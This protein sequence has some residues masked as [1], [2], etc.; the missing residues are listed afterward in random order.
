MNKPLCHVSTRDI[1]SKHRVERDTENELS[2]SLSTKH[3][4]FP[5]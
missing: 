4:P 2:K 3:K 5:L 1:S